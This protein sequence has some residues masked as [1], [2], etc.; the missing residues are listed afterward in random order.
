MDIR[1]QLE[2]D[3]DK[4]L[5][6]SPNLQIMKLFNTLKYSLQGNWSAAFKCRTKAPRPVS[7]DPST[8]RFY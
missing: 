2:A 3:I 1:Q 4:L 5:Y 7:S 8:S 6:L